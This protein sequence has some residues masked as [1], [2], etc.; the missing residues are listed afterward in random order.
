MYR[1][2]QVG[3]FCE[4]LLIR[5]CLFV[6]L[7]VCLFAFV[8]C[9]FVLFCFVLFCIVLFC[10]VLFCV[11]LYCIV[12]YC[13]VCWIFLCT[14]TSCIY[15][16]IYHSKKRLRYCDQKC[17][18]LVEQLKCADILFANHSCIS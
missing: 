7:F 12:L 4:N 6:C 17:V 5:F 8:L 3:I 2:F 18:I 15:I 10:V 1:S 9:C 14:R 11:V 16:Y 13:F